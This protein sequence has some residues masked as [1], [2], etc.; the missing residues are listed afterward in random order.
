MFPD[1]Y[2]HAG[3]DEVN[4]ACWEDDPVVRGFLADGG[5]HDRLLELF[6]NATRPFL[7]HEL[8]RTSVYWEDVLLGPKVSVGQTVLPHD[9]T[10][11]QTWNNGAENTKPAAGVVTRGQLAP[12][13]PPARRPHGGVL[14]AGLQVTI[15]MV[16]LDC[17]PAG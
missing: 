13:W 5:S 17:W 11:L 12:R 9:T 6:L 10:V 3:A 16:L 7:V 14:G 1:P 8:N 4:T 15:A 2:L